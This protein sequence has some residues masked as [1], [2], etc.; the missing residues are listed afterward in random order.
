MVVVVVVVVVVGGGG[1][2]Q[3]ERDRMFECIGA[4]ACHACIPV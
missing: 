4:R 2:V 1:E 3:C